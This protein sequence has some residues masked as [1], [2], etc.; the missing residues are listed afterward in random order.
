P[1]ISI[2]QSAPAIEWQRTW[3]SS[4]EDGGQVIKPTNDGGYM[5]I[6]S[7]QA[8]D[9]DVTSYHGGYSDAWVLK[10]DATGSL[11]WQRTFGGSGTDHAEDIQQTAD[12]GYIVAASTTSNDGDVSGNHGNRDVWLIKLDAQGE[13][14]WQRCYGG[15]SNDGAIAVK[16]T[17]DGGY[18]LAATT[19]SND[20]DVSGNHGSL[21]FWVIKLDETGNISWQNTY[22]GSGYDE[23]ADLKKTDDGGYI[24]MGTTSSTDGDITHPASYEDAWVVKLDPEGNIM[25]DQTLGG[26]G[27]DYGTS[28]KQTA[29]HGFVLVGFSNGDSFGCES[30]LFYAYVAKLNESGVLEWELTCMGGTMPDFINDVIQTPDGGYV[31]AGSTESDDGDI[32]FNHGMADSWLVRLDPQG[33]VLWQRT[34]GGSLA[35]AAYG[36]ASTSDGGYVVAGVTASSDGDVTENKG[37]L[38]IWIV[39]LGPDPVGITEQPLPAVFSLSPNPASDVINIHF[40]EALPNG[41]RLKIVDAQGRHLATPHEGNVV[42]VGSDVQFSVAHLPAGVYAVQ[43]SSE[44]GTWTQRFVKE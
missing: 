6:G 35:D 7:T 39:K 40:E 14:Q 10:L 28:I 29:D 22:G 1:F 31:L 15:S 2:A 13:L 21:D 11:E 23:A 27:D 16:L 30:G 4:G 25:W 26:P 9:G 17:Q 12:G 34:L 33:N 36:I 20:G 18:I 44:G 5:V 19:N 3:G 41:A 38:D 8:A 43:L 37:M 42:A 32:S 24:L